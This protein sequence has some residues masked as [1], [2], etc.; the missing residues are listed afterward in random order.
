MPKF[1]RIKEDE[2]IQSL[3]D[4]LEPIHDVIL[5]PMDLFSKECKVGV[6]MSYIEDEN[7]VAG[8]LMY[9][10]TSGWIEIDQLHIDKE[11]RGGTIIKHFFAKV[12]TISTI[13]NKRMRAKITNEG[14][15]KSIGHMLEP[16][17]EK[18]DNWWEVFLR[19]KK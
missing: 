17:P 10:T 4:Y 9:P 11:Y 5:P 6:A 15:L 2:D 8:L 13:K 7:I 18:G 3:Y 19:R 16:L 1:K 14:M 12:L